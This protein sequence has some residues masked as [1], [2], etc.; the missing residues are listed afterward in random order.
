M[1]SKDFFAPTPEQ[2]LEAAKQFKATLHFMTQPSVRGPSPANGYQGQQG[3]F[4]TVE[5]WGLD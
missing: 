3:F 1:Y 4:A 5:Y 2:A